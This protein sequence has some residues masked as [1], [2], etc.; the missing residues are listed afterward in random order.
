LQRASKRALDRA[1]NGFTL[2]ELLIV[3]V[4]IGVVIAAVALSIRNS[5]SSQESRSAANIFR[6]RAIYAEQLAI[7]QAT[8]IGLAVTQEGYQFYDL[9]SSGA[10][11]QVY[12][13]PA[14]RQ[15][16]NYQ[17]WPKSMNLILTLPNNPNTLIPNQ[18]PEQ[19]M[20]VFNPSGGVTPFTLKIDNFTVSAKENGIIDAS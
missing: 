4:I 17:A 10:T 1:K 6:A 12:W 14:T 20:I 13:Q 18:L 8:T 15:A 19:P 7:I 2:L 11:G 9:Q 5:G 3:L 16:L